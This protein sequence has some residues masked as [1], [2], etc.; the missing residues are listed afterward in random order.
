MNEY[1]IYNP[2]GTTLSSGGSGS[3]DQIIDYNKTYPADITDEEYT[4]VGADTFTVGTIKRAFKGSTDLKI[5]TAEDEGG[6]ELIE[7]TDYTVEDEDFYY[8]ED[9]GYHCYTGI[10]VINVTY[11]SG[12]LYITYKAVGTYT[13]AG[14]YAST[15]YADQVGV[16]VGFIFPGGMIDTP[17]HCLLIDGSAISRSTYATLYAALTKTLGAVTIS[18]AT[19]GVGTLN[20]HALVSGDCIE[21][22]TDGGLP[23][24][25]SVNTNYYI[26]WK[27]ANSFYFHAA[28]STAKAGTSGS[29]IATSSAG[30]GTHMLRWCPF[31]ISTAANFLLPDGR[32]VVP[33]GVGT[34]TINTRAKTGPCFGESEEDQEQSHVHTSSNADDYYFRVSGGSAGLAAGSYTI[35]SKTSAGPSVDGSYGTPRIGSTT[36]DN[37]IGVNYYIKYE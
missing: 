34:Q 9:A 33:K 8:L 6:T 12:D 20:G 25:L 27:D 14:A 31:G 37:G 4:D 22:T 11:Q 2:D 13:K 29:R 36:R 17:A 19:P 28:R 24:G 7:N 21:L 5:F 23:T 10:K 26:E 15:A 3:K 32:A 30:S 16:A 35:V 1:V 18:N